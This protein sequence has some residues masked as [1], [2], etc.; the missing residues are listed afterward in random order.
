MRLRYNGVC[1]AC[2]HR[3]VAGTTAVYDRTSRTVRCIECAPSTG[4]DR[5]DTAAAF[6]LEDAGPVH[7]SA[8]ASAR[9]EFERRQS[10]REQRVRANHPKLGG[11]LLA[12]FDDP[13][14]TRSWATGADGEERLGARLDVQAGP[15][16]RVLHDLRVPGRRG[17]IDHIVVCPSGVVVIDAKKYKGR[18]QLR[19]EGGLL[20]PRSERLMVSGRDC[21]RL[22][23]GVRS[24]GGRGPHRAWAIGR[25]ARKAAGH[26]S[27]L[28]PRPRSASTRR[29]A[30]E[31]GAAPRKWTCV[32]QASG[33]AGI[34]ARVGHRR[35]PRLDGPRV[36]MPP[37]DLPK[38]A[39]R[40]ITAM[41]HLALGQIQADR[42]ASAPCP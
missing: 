29:C 23:D 16:L 10:A 32:A 42:C 38:A 25:G 5:V 13:Q 39:R 27:I 8:G 2:G 20:R 3:L 17:N 11:L 34:R 40:P 37:G 4:P 6:E 36:A 18:P 12:L 28:L 41:S 26:H 14:S 15:L 1:R 21:S 24:R 31:S 7:G 33:V 19:V 22:V 9:R 35:V 30:V